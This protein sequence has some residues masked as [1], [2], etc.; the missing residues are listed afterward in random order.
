MR[1]HLFISICT[2]SVFLTAAAALPTDAAE[3]STGDLIKSPDTSD[4][5]YYGADG[6]RYAF[7]NEKTFFTWYDA[8]NVTTLTASEVAAIPFG[9]VV[10]YRPGERMVKLTTDPKTYAVDMGGVLR[11]VTSEQ[12]AAELYGAAWADKIDDLPDTFFATYTLGDPIAGLA[13]FNPPA[14]RDASPSITADKSLMPPEEPTPMPQPENGAIT[15]TSSHQTLRAGDVI[16]LTATASHPSGIR[17]IEIYF[18]GT[19]MTRCMVFSCSGEAVV[20][21]SGTKESYTARA[22][23]TATDN[24]VL[25]HTI[26]MPV[27]GQVSDLVRISIGRSKIRPGQPAEAVIDADPSIAVSRTD[28]YID[29]RAI[30]ACLSSSRQCR[31]SDTLSGDIGT[32]HTAYG[33]VKDTIGRTYKSAVKTITIADNDSPIVELVIGSDTVKRNATSDVAA[34]ASDDDGIAKIEIMVDG[35]VVTTCPN[36]LSCTA[37]IGPWGEPGVHTVAARA[38]DGLGETEQT[39]PVEITVTSS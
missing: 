11:W 13:D 18:D 1:R 9:G 16:T 14:R 27:D 34:N 38:E 37:D 17:Q 29:D 35:A 3:L 19:L 20:P 36:A 25:E 15:F 24:S 7:P 8:F 21:I 31:W 23:A 2:L 32:V 39:E 6:K 10:T 4:V 30:K 33:I 26:A 5:Y 12:V 22:V 28:I